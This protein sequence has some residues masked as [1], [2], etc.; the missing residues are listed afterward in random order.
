V[1]TVPKA[2]T[3]AGAGVGTGTGAL[4]VLLA[5]AA[6]LACDRPNGSGLVEGVFGV[7]GCRP[8]GDRPVESYRFNAGALSTDRFNQE[9]EISIQEHMVRLEETDG[10]L[11]RITDINPLLAQTARP[12]VLPINRDPYGVN[13]TLSLFTTCPS[14]PTLIASTGTL[15]FDRFTINLDPTETGDHEVLTGSAT[16]TLVTV[17]TGTVGTL[18]IRFDFFPPRQPLNALPP[19]DQI[20]APLTPAR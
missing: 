20:S 1:R 2:G 9:L 15:S 17:A 5:A 7:R 10:V 18:H 3:G 19:I 14:W 13:L 4:L 11:I 8:S 12:I 6:F 16:V